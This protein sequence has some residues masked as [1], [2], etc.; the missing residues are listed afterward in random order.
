LDK[1]VTAFEPAVALFVPDEN[2]LLFYEKIARFATTHLKKGGKI[3]MET[4][5]NFAK[6]VAALFADSNA[7]AEVKKDIS[8]KERMVVVTTD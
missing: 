2:P 3:F 7:V 6:Q 8:G 5:E 1:N 4:H